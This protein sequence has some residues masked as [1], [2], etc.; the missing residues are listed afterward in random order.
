[1]GK[2][3]YIFL[4]LG[5]LLMTSPGI[6]ARNWTLNDCINYALQNNITIQKNTLTRLSAIEDIKQSQA[7]L[8]PSLSVSTS[9]SGSFTPWLESGRAT[10][11]NGYVQTSVDKV[12]Y[13]GM[14]GVDA[15]WTVWNGGKNINTVKL[16]KLA[17]E[18]AELDS[19]TTA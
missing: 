15:N 9:Q 7:S 12:Y 11:A 8:L 2:R 6:T 14:Y 10:V 18:K 5:L 16:N 4:L 3:K 19:A 1:M 17:A 13:N